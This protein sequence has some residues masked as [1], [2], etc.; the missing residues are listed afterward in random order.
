M[1]VV[2]RRGVIGE[3][4]C[5][6]GWRC[7][8]RWRLEFRGCVGIGGGGLRFEIERDCKVIVCFV[9]RFIELREGILWRRNGL[10]GEDRRI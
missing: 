10:S 4:E 8:L 2:A 3:W 6:A 7:M 9:I 1:V 5:G